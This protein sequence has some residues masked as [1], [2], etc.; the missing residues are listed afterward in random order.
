MITLLEQSILDLV[1]K[2]KYGK[3][4]VEIEDKEIVDV[5][6]SHHHKPHDLVDK[7]QIK[8]QNIIK[9]A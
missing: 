4:I 8:A 7:Q 1:R 2:I 9:R 3:V 6:E 5:Y